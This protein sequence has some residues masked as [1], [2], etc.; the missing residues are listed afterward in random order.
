MPAGGKREG[1]GRPKGSPNKRSATIRERLEALN[2]D[3][4]GLLAMMVNNQVP[5]A[6]CG[7]A[8]KTKFQPRGGQT[9]SGTRTCQSCWGSGME[10]IGPKDRGWAAAE[11]LSYCEAKR[12][13]VEVSN[14]DGTMQK[15]WVVVERSVDG[16]TDRDTPQV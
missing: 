14:P 7:G 4:I 10:R 12:K 15:T 2:C 5:C 11:L 6:T 16:N 3:Y 1:G 13:A 8:G 9:F